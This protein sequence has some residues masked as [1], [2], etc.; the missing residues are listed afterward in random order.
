MEIDPPIR[1]GQSVD[2]VGEGALPINASAK[3]PQPVELELFDVTGK[4]MGALSS[5]SW[6]AGRQVYLWAL[7]SSENVPNGVYLLQVSAG[8]ER[9]L[10]RV[11]VQR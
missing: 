1:A 5:I 3:R 4:D 7:P 11:V 2:R 8:M 9:Q 6:P 10:V